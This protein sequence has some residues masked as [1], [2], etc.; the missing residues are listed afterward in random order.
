MIHSD[1]TLRCFP[2]IIVS[3]DKYKIDIVNIC[4]SKMKED[5]VTIIDL[6]KDPYQG[7]LLSELE[8]KFNYKIGFYFLV[9][10][11]KTFI[12]LK[13]YR[14]S[15]LLRQQNILTIR[16]A[17]FHYI[18]NM[19][20][21]GRM[22]IAY[23]SLCNL[24]RMKFKLLST[25]ENIYFYIEELEDA[26]IFGIY[27]D[28]T[29]LTHYNPTFSQ[30]LIRLGITYQDHCDPYDRIYDICIEDERTLEWIY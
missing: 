25:K 20:N 24:Y 23:T 18:I 13:S 8:N 27:L 12:K 1:F 26:Y 11:E 2:H 6:I 3:K 16:D 30:E 22:L 7:I 15:K 29:K 4:R 9:A 21:D 28:R 17:L 10:L 19:E 14:V 5:I